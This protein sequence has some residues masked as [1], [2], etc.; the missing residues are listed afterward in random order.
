[1]IQAT[2]MSHY[3][4]T[5]KERMK[6]C[7][8]ILSNKEFYLEVITSR[9]DNGEP[10]TTKV[11][12]NIWNTETAIKRLQKGLKFALQMLKKERKESV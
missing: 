9:Y 6:A 7:W 3:R 8:L 12:S 2:K 1:M 4:L 5:I 10:L 11:I